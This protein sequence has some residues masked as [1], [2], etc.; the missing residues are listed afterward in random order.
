MIAGWSLRWFP[1]LPTSSTPGALSSQTRHPRNIRSHDTTDPAWNCEI[2]RPS[3]LLH[4]NTLSFEP[5]ISFSIFR[6]CRQLAPDYCF[7]LQT[8]ENILLT[9]FTT[10]ETQRRVPTSSRHDVL[11]ATPSAKV[12]ETRSVPTCTG[13][14]AATP[15]PSQ[16]S[17]TPMPTRQRALSG[18]RTLWYVYGSKFWNFGSIMLTKL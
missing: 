10:Q 7:Q 9:D 5:G 8:S 3:Y 18:R 4:T 2:S 14:S 17:H 12:K 11:N 13:C 6:C 15:V 16:A 1:A